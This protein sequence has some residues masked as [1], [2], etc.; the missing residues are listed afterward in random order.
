MTARSETAELCGILC[1]AVSRDDGTLVFAGAHQSEYQSWASSPECD[2]EFPLAAVQRVRGEFPDK[3][4]K[5]QYLPPGAP[6]DWLGDT[7]LRSRFVLIKKVRPL[8]RFAQMS[9]DSLNKAN[10]KKRLK[11][12]KKLGEI[13]FR[14]LTSAD[15]LEAVFDDFA[16]FCNLRL[17]AMHD[18]E[19]FADDP[20]KRLF[21]LEMMRQPGLVHATILRAGNLLASAHFNMRDRKQLHLNLIAHNPILAKHSPGKFHVHMLSQMLI[22]EGYE[23]LDLTPGGDPYKERFANAHDSV[24]VLHFP[25]TKVSRVKLMLQARGESWARSGLSAVGVHP[26]RARRLVGVARDSSLKDVVAPL[27]RLGDCVH[28]TRETKLYVRQIAEPIAA[29]GDGRLFRRDVINDLLNYRVPPGGL[30][31]KRFLFEAMDRL[32]EGQHLY[33]CVRE[34]GLIYLGWVIERP[35]EVFVSRVLPGLTLPADSALILDLRAC[36]PAD[37]AELGPACLS[38]ML[39]D[40]SHANGIQRAVM[41]V[42]ANPGQTQWL[43]AAGF[44]WERSLFVKNSFG[45]TRHWT[46]QASPSVA[47]A[48]VQ[49]LP[50]SANH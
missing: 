6:L 49:M 32:E 26:A 47:T 8:L 16:D 9:A 39:A 46:W 24:S 31:R 33:S 48:K 20:L 4:L 43:E 29:S 5:F 14:R 7:R 15:E 27:A 23:E 42:S 11:G 28:S 12:L 37:G 25:A 41:A 30:P 17:G 36:V 1:L 35:S 18:M 34:G 10:N 2:S 13:E 40:L 38:A 19:P 50:V 22:A 3:P 45:R 44:S 21:H